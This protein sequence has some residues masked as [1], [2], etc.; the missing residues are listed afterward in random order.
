MLSSGG[1]GYFEYAAE[2]DGNQTLGLDVPLDQVDDV[3]KSLV[4]FD[5]SGAVAGVELP[6]Q[7][8]IIAAFGDLPFGPEALKSPTDYLNALRGTEVSVQGTKPMTGRLLQVE[9]ASE[10]TDKTSVQRNRVTLL[11]IE[12]LRQFVLEDA[13]AVQV[14]DPVLRARIDRALEAMRRDSGRT[15]R[16]LTIRLTGDGK[17]DVAVGFVAGAPLWKATYRLILPSTASGKARLQGWATLE[18]QSAA[19]WKGVGLTLQYGN[20]VTFRQALYRSYV[21]QRPVVPVEILGQLLPAPDTRA[22]TVPNPMPAEGLLRAPAMQQA[23]QKQFGSFAAA[24]A[25]APAPPPPPMAAPA[26][27]AMTDESAEETL[28]TLAHPVD[29]D[30]GHSANLPIVDREIP[31]E[32]VGLVPYPQTHPLSSIRIKNE[33][34]QSLPA[35]VLTLYDI[36]ANVG[37]AGDA[38]LGGL[39]SGETR[40]L[41]FARD[42]RT[43]IDT[44]LSSQPNLVSSFSV[45]DGVLTYVLRSRQVI[46]MTATAPANE[47]RDLLLELPK[48]GMDQTLTVADGKAA[49]AAATATAWRLAMSLKPGETQQVTVHLDQPLRNTTQLL[50]GDDSILLTIVGN[51]GLN[52]TGRASLRQIIELRRDEARKRVEVDTL[53]KWLEDVRSDEE[54]IRNNLS[55]VAAGDALRT[56]LTKSLDADETKIEQLQAKIVEA[57]T[58]ADKARRTLADAVAA[59]RI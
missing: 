24:T 1:I 26:Q 40:L 22:L 30:A 56:R 17:R 21:V 42:L 49:L 29:L 39:P 35:G 33:N 59:L 32:R 20:P 48:G 15:T 11:T 58:A 28:F 6:G 7:D 46:R 12:G 3:L 43:A 57:T 38:R 54:R 47:A 51:D 25:P 8:D 19:D 37:F 10:T 36:R 13:D 41:S 52:A 27:M 2:V 23:N 34:G 31:A 45:A 4:V 9:P 53:R 50:S 44:K 55:A 16:H 18:N 14:V 5:K